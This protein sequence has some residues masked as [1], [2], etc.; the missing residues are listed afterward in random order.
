M[1]LPVAIIGAGP[2]GIAA[3]VQL[4][5][6][7]IDFLIFE[8][9]VIGGLLNEAQRVENFPGIPGGLPGRT[10][11]ARLKRQLDASGI[12]VQMS[13]V[14]HL[15]FRDGAFAIRTGKGVRQAARTILACGSTPI[16]AGP[17]LDP[18]RLRGRLFASVLPLLKA[19]GEA[20]AVIGG[21][22]AACD[23]ALNLAAR[24]QVHVLVRSS[25]P[26]ALPLLLER[27]RRHR[28]I[29]IHENCRLIRVETRGGMAE[30]VLKT[31]NPLDGSRGEIAC[32]RI[33]TAIGR[34]P[35]L[36]FLDPA[37]RSSLSKLGKKKKIYLAGDVGNGRFR[38]AAIAAA[39]GLRAA[40][41]IQ[42]EV[43][44]CG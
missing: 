28:N 27:C 43:S 10:L 7:G 3:A 1:T 40:M 34:A 13:S 38:Q 8:G 39:D 37:L 41:E 26:R 30:V 36:Q 19:R 2:A 16:A 31:L 22:D 29:I 32:R 25:R 35:A 12:R 20:I 4:R 14:L 44:R 11:A 24:N 33:L 21:G 18:E 5:R 15:S 42:E 6:G 9:G 17:P 23:Y